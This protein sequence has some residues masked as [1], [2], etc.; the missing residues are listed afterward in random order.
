MSPS[1]YI[2]VEFSILCQSLLF[3]HSFST[4]VCQ[5]LL[6]ILS[7]SFSF[8]FSVSHYMDLSCDLSYSFLLNHRPHY[9]NAHIT[10]SSFFPHYCYHCSDLTT[11][12]GNS[13][14]TSPT[15]PMST[16]P[17]GGWQPF[18]AEPPSSRC[19]FAR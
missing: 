5:S 6:C 7:S 11:S 9:I 18:G 17:R 15:Y 4:D 3:S 10:L 14:R 2:N 19:S 8:I 13:T 16:S 1:W 12:T